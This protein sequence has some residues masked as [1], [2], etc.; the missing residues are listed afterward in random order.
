MG[1]W[2]KLF[3]KFKE[4]EWYDNS[5]VKVLFL[6]LLLTVNY[7]DKTWHGIEIKR[8]QIL[9]GIEE[10]GKRVGLN[11]QQTRTAIDKLTSTKEITKV[12]TPLYTIITVNN[13]GKYQ[14]VTNP[15]TFEQPRSNQGL[16]TTKEIKKEK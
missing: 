16:T 15:I 5:N 2:I 1:N 11:R 3:R 12:S 4:W 10:L 13:Y 14:D 8:G 6:E 9:T 7:E